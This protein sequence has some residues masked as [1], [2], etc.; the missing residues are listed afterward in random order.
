[1]RRLVWLSWKLLLQTLTL[2]A[3][4]PLSR[5]PLEALDDAV[6]DRA[7]QRFVHLRRTRG[8]KKTQATSASVPALVDR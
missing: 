8:K 3:Q 4:R 1:M 7:Q 2:I 6:F 5:A